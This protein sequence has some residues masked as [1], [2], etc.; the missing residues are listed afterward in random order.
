MNIDWAVTSYLRKQNHIILDIGKDLVLIEISIFKPNSSINKQPAWESLLA[1]LILP[2]LVSISFESLLSPHAC[3]INL[4]R[5]LLYSF[6]E[7]S[8]L[9]LNESTCRWSFVYVNLSEM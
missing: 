9:N 5:F 6:Q 7:N 1:V 3:V 4:F 2:D 8:P